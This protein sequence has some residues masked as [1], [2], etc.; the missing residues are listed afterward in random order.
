[1][2]AAL[3]TL[4]VLGLELEGRVLDVEVAAQA[5]PQIVEDRARIRPSFHH[6][7][8]GDDIHATGDRPH[9]EI[10]DVEHAAAR[11]DVFPQGVDFTSRGVASRST[12][13][14]SRSRLNDRGTIS[15]TIRNAANMS[16]T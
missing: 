12:S 2:R 16:A 7:V 13:I 9:V 6:D 8:G 3:E 4:A 11:E 1:M 14:A 5:G 10:V 15:A